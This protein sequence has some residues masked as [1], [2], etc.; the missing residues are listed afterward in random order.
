M[1][2][3]HEDLRDNVD[4]NRIHDYEAEGNIA[5]PHHNHSRRHNSPG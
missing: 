3:T 4:A 5:N 1:D 2:H